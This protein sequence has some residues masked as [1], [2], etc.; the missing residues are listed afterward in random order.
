MR[1]R[2]SSLSTCTTVDISGLAIS[3]V[4]IREL[5]R[6]C[7]QDSTLCQIGN[8]NEN[9]YWHKDILFNLNQIDA[10]EQ[11][12]HLMKTSNLLPNSECK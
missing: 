11:C 9:T 5:F 3:A 8:Y 6:T 10:K 2:N 7:P 1:A 4:H 12:E